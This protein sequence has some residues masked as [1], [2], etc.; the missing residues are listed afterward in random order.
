MKVTSETLTLHCKALRGVRAYPL[1]HNEHTQSLKV[2]K[3]HFQ[4]HAVASEV[5]DTK[6]GSLDTKPWKL[7]HKISSAWTSGAR[8]QAC[9][10]AE[11]APSAPDS[12]SSGTNGTSCT[13][14]HLYNHGSAWR[15]GTHRRKTPL[16]VPESRSKAAKR[17]ELE[18]HQ[19]H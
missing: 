9:T 3:T 12:V 1:L 11:T 7:R 16:R 8:D 19:T 13:P 14:S 17:W 2:D 6:L 5:L 4:P 18:L 15:S 10:P